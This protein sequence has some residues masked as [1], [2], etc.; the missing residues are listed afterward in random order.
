MCKQ[1]LCPGGVKSQDQ[2][3]SA[4]LED[5]ARPHLITPKF[6]PQS[7]VEL[8]EVRQRV[9][10]NI[11]HYM[12]FPLG[13]LTVNQLEMII[14]DSAWCR[15]TRP[16][17]CNTL[18]DSLKGRMKCMER[19]IQIHLSCQNTHLTFL[20]S[21]VFDMAHYF[22]TTVKK[23]KKTKKWRIHI[24]QRNQCSAQHFLTKLWI[25]RAANLF[26]ISTHFTGTCRCLEP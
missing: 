26:R 3:S 19:K 5:K 1:K 24:Q 2:P 12:E 18:N 22:N 23:K 6:Q 4:W 15:T 17:A 21:I 16:H 20:L 25:S 8:N 13:R 10:S 11:S 14:I 9:E 7:P